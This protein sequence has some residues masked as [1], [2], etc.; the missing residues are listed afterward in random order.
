MDTPNTSNNPNP[1][2]TTADLTP[3]E[4]QSSSTTLSLPL[5]N[6]AI[7]SATPPLTSVTAPPLSLTPDEKRF[8]LFNVGSP[9]EVP[10][11]EFDKNWWPLVSNV[12][13]QYNSRKHINGDTCKV[14]TCRFTKHRDSSER[15]DKEIPTKKRRTTMI[16]PPGLCHAKIKVLRL[17][18]TKM[19]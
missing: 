12:W 17:I 16:R 6:T 19:V 15:K 10:E 8:L 5:T 4:K 1:S 11:E 2:L 18:S 7:T 13:T 3:D 9:F 14:F